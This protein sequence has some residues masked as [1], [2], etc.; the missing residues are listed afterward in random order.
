MNKYVWGI[1]TGFTVGAVLA[2]SAYTAGY[3]AL[4]NKYAAQM[5][6][7]DISGFK[8][9][10]DGI[11]IDE[12]AI[13][14]NVNLKRVYFHGFPWMLYL[15]G[16]DY[17]NVLSADIK[18]DNLFTQKILWPFNNNAP[19]VIE[20]INVNTNLMGTAL[21]FSGNAKQTPETPLL[22]DFQSNDKALNLS[23]QAE[24]RFKDGMLETTDIKFE[25]SSAD[26]ALIQTKRMSGWA[27]YSFDQEWQLVGEIDAGFTKLI[28]REFSDATL[29]LTGFANA[30]QI[31][32]AGNEN[33]EAII[34]DKKDSD[35]TILRKEQI[36]PVHA[37]QLDNQLLTSI[38]QTFDK[39]DQLPAPEE[40]KIIV[41]AVEKPKKKEE[42][43]EI[44]KPKVSVEP[45]SEPDQVLKIKPEIKPNEEAKVEDKPE[46]VK[47]ALPSIRLEFLTG[48]SDLKGF[49]YT[50]SVTP[51]SYDC[52]KATDTNCWIAQGLGGEFTYNPDNL[53]N[54]FLKIK[55]Y[56]ELVQLKTALLKFVVESITVQGKEQ[57]ATEI[58]LKG[59]TSGGQPAEIQLS[60]LAG[61]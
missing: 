31:T 19:F 33:G 10:V 26:L 37:D 3:V 25:D 52:A 6:S 45:K 49:F 12:I 54:Y 17:I 16:P 11:V 32:F 61:E 21:A 38:V 42:K 59:T 46:L 28:S 44:V 15:S 47:E 48:N 30:P 51:V 43:A 24:L 35:V 7:A 41:A 1:A 4:K 13:N 27:S 50:N 29:K 9:Y 39:I 58:N 5:A 23:G 55:N 22:V 18:T 8:L 36:F 40:K 20:K 57:Q 34:I 14:K 53:P 2:A 60:V 56:Q